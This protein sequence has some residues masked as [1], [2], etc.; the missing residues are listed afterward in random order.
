MTAMHEPSPMP[1]SDGTRQERDQLPVILLVDDDDATRAQ[2][3]EIVD[4]RFGHDYDVTAEPSAA[5]AMARLE[6]LHDAGRSVGLIIADHYMPEE[7]GASFL[8][9]SRRLHPTAQR[10]LMTDWADFSAVDETVHGMILGEFDTWIGRPLGLADEEFHGNVT[11]ALARFA[12]ETGRGGV[13]VTIVGNPY[14]ERTAALRNS[15]AR[16]MAPYR[17]MDAATV[18]GQAHLDSLGTDGPLPVVSLADGRT[19]T[20][21]GTL[22]L[23]TA[24]GMPM[25]I[26]D[27]RVDVAVIGCGPAGLAAA[28]YAATEGLSVAVIEPSDP[29][30]QASSSPMLRNYLGFPAGVTGAELTSRAFQ[31]AVS[32]GAR[33]IFGRTVTA[34][35]A[36]G[37]DRLLALDDGSEIRAGSV[38]ISTGVS[39]RRVGIE[40]L[41]ALVGRGV[42]YGSGMSE[43]A[44]L[45]GERVYVVGGANSAGSAAVHLARHAEHVT[46]LVRG[47]SIVDTMSDYLIQEMDAAGNIDIRLNT[48]ITDAHGDFRLRGLT[49]RDRVSGVTEDVPAAAAF[50]LIGAA[51]R[52]EWLPD[53]ITRDDHGFIL[54]GEQRPDAADGLGLHTTMPGVFAAGDVRRNPVKRIAAAVGDGSSAIRQIHEYRAGARERAAVG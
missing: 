28:V 5:A 35:R 42:F 40:R 30:G 2:L 50:I 26:E 9:R 29:G 18:A 45:E 33:F 17:F 46:L 37:D 11:A 53:E 36:D 13:V 39:Y 6:R 41:E 31:Q 52:T 8:A 27:G 1:G 38:V 12:R 22:D 43:A 25:S 32:F 20:G 44:S 51:P 49:L 4:R 24:L 21:A 7:T 48:E 16:L 47:G 23:A 3:L 14:D 34:L 19:I 54:T 15:L 10:M